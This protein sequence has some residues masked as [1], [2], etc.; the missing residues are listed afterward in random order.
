[1]AENQND[2]ERGDFVET[3]IDLDRAEL[4]E[5]LHDLQER[6]IE[7]AGHKH[8]GQPYGA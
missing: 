4:L 6:S 2:L 7:R 8:P 3:Y 1:M 5:I